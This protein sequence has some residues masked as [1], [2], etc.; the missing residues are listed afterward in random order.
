MSLCI[1]LKPPYNAELSCTLGLVWS[2]QAIV[3]GSAQLDRGFYSGKRQSRGLSRGS[4]QNV[5]T[6]SRGSL[7]SSR[8]VDLLSLGLQK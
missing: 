5:E 1:K 8:K 4:G 6:W 7:L 2:V 3:S